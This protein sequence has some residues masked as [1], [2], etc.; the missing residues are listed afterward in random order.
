MELRANNPAKTYVR[1][2]ERRRSLLGGK[3][4]Y[5]DAFTLDCVLRDISDGGA[6]ITL[7]TGQAVP[8]IFYLMDLRSGVAFQVQVV[9]RSYPQIGVRFAH[10]YGDQSPSNPH[11]QVLRSIWKDTRQLSGA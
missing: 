4:L 7:P 6:R 5:G 2:A 11:V 9:W 10:E 3:I 8:D 1:S